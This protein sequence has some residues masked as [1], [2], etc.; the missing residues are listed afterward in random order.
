VGRAKTRARK[1]RSRRDNMMNRENIY[2]E[3]K[4]E[5]NREESR[6]AEPSLLIIEK[7]TVTNLR[8]CLV[9]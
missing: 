7:K 5:R 2:T 9:R 4:V 6:T 3:E 8:G 1:G